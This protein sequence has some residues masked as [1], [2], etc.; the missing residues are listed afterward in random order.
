V[1]AVPGLAA[2]LAGCSVALAGASLHAWRVP[3][4]SMEPTL[5]PGA[6]V[7]TKPGPVHVRLD[8]VVIVHPPRGALRGALGVCGAHVASTQVCLDPTGGRSSTFYIERV[9]ALGGQR[10]AL[11]G[12][13]VV[14]DGKLQ[15]EPFARV[16]TCALARICN[17]PNAVTVP[18]GYVFL[19]G[20]N[21][22]R[23][24]DSRFWGPVPSSWIV[25]VAQ[26]CDRGQK[27]CHA[28]G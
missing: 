1:L 19:L 12:G 27:H 23:S 22:A 14:R 16:S 11:F 24:D 20:D 17:Y 10:I 15:A 21:R 13:H 8:E 25:G 3:A 9:V 26:T 7:Y 4:A 6:V 18:R 5:R 2:V 28:A